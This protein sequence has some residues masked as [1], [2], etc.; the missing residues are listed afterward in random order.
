MTDDSPSLSAKPPGTVPP[1]SFLRFHLAAEAAGFPALLIVTMFC[2][3]A[4]VAAVALLAV[5]ATPWVLVLTM[6]VLIAA[7]GI[8]AGEID[9]A[10]RDTT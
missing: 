8:M 1:N 5:I 2:L 9:A 3:V 4:V 7:V 10:F 6:L